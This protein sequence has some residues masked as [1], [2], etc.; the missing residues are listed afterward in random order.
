MR[1]SRRSAAALLL[2]GVLLVGL[3]ITA[4]VLFDRRDERTLREGRLAEGQVTRLIEPAGWDPLDSG[5]LEITYELDGHTRRTQVW[6]DNELTDYTRGQW[7]ELRIRGHHVRTDREANDPA[8]VGMALVLAGLAGLGAATFG[9]VR[10]LPSGASAE[11]PPHALDRIPLKTWR[12]SPRKAVIDVLPEGL[13]FYLPSFFGSRRFTVS[14]ADVVVQRLDAFTAL[15][16]NDQDVFFQ[17]EVRTAY[18][19]TTSSSAAP[20]L[21]LAFARPVRVPRL[22]LIMALS[23]NVDLPFGWR[24]SRS[25]K[26][27]HLDGVALRV[28]DPGRA[29]E[30]LRAAGVRVVDDVDTWLAQHRELETDPATLEELREDMAAGQ[31]AQRWGWLFVPGALL[32]GVARFTEDLRF[33]APGVVLTALGFG[34]PYVTMRLARRRRQKASQR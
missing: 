6:L 14:R 18:F 9:G 17:D 23:D 15:G 22:R 11:V 27:A 10:L 33:A 34:A 5:R 20:N 25:D 12:L 31:R 16:E 21:A 7:V 1:V 24:E 2:S 19:P 8:P 4:F 13:S 26:G 3:V 29:I 28:A 30:Q 32:L